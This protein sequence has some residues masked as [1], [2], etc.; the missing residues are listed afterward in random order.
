MQ[1][2][3]W[4][5]ACAFTRWCTV[6]WITFAIM[7]TCPCNA[8]AAAPHHLT[9]VLVLCQ[10]GSLC[11]ATS[12]THACNMPVGYCVPAWSA[13]HHSCSG[14]ALA[15]CPASHS[16]GRLADPAGPAAVVATGSWL[17]GLVSPS[18]HMLCS[19]MVALL[20]VAADYNSLGR[21]VARGRIPPGERHCTQ[22]TH[23]HT[24]CTTASFLIHFGAAGLLV[25]RICYVRDSST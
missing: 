24:C 17:W 23:I 8:R 6:A 20:A 5:I 14:S 15:A 1:Q 19:A 4:A 10:P 12:C 3:A 16:L 22:H 13:K 9:S 2:Q 18:S 7:S 11:C 25:S 21:D